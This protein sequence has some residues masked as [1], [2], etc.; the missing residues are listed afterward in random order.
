MPIKQREENLHSEVHS[1]LP[2]INEFW[3]NQS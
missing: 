2:K 1:H 3:F